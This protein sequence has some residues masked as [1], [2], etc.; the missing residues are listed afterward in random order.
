MM[1]SALWPGIWLHI[2]Q[3][4]YINVCICFTAH[5]TVLS[6]L[7]TASSCCFY[8]YLYST[9]LHTFTQT[10]A[11]ISFYV[12]SHISLAHHIENVTHFTT[13]ILSLEFN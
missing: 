9:H 4:S 1:F 13:L 7:H 12:P 11:E 6:K 8:E 5:F 2:E 3:D 10:V